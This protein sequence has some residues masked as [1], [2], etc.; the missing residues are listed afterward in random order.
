M[1]KLHTHPGS[2]PPPDLPPHQPLKTFT[3]TQIGALLNEKHNMPEGAETKYKAEL[4][5]HCVN[6]NRLSFTSTNK[7]KQQLTAKMRCNVCGITVDIDVINDHVCPTDLFLK[8]APTKDKVN[9]TSDD[10][11]A[12]INK[13]FTAE[14]LEKNGDQYLKATTYSRGHARRRDKLQAD[15]VKVVKE[16]KELL[17]PMAELIE[18]PNCSGR[19]VPKAFVSLGG[20]KKLSTK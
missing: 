6:V 12:L 7:N 14:E 16:N 3:A 20:E 2:K 17:G 11:F 10:E 8:R 9:Y 1:P 19:M 13:G 15:L 5:E 18:D 4:G